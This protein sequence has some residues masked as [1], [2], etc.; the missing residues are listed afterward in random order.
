MK[1]FALIENVMQLNWS[2]E[3]QEQLKIQKDFLKYVAVSKVVPN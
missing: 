3:D 1:G 2:Q